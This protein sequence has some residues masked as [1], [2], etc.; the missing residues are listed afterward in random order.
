LPQNYDKTHPYTLIFQAPGCGYTGAAVY[1][2]T[3]NVNDTAI[4]VGLTP[5]PNSL[6][7]G[8]YPEQSCFDS[9]E[10][11]DSIDFVFYETLFDRLSAELCFDKTRVFASGD[12]IG[13]SL[14]NELGC[15]Y[16]G[17]ALRPIRGVLVNT[18]G[19]PTQPAYA[20]S[21]VNQPL[22]GMWV[23]ETGDLTTP[24]SGNKVAIDRAM[25]VNGCN[26][27]TS[28]DTAQF[29][30]YPI[31]GGNADS[32]CQKIKGCPDLY[33]LVVCALPGNQHGS[34]SAVVNPGF[35]TFVTGLPAL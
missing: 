22:A 18:G 32:T 20:P 9:H 13:G 15:K 16:A 27:G 29:Q 14:A 34:H 6:G 11:D 5:G 7:H 3:N 2:L 4:R 30:N 21:C 35:A 17:D 12:S 8:V 24:F 28:Y 10:G 26:I 1:P 31:G 23:H 33:P 25:K 19:L